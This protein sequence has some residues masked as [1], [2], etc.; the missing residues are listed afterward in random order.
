MGRQKEKTKRATIDMEMSTFH[1]P[2]SGDVLVLAKRCPIGP[3]AAKKMLDTV[4]PHQFELIQLEDNLIDGILV[5]KYLFLRAD[6]ESLIK[7]IIEEAKAVMGD[8][9][10]ICIKCEIT[11]RV[12]REI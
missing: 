7:T 3:Q 9:C 10:M 12:K 2:P 11:L 4:A 5:K 8:Q 1:I 6:K